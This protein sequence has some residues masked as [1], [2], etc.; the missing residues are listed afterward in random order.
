[1]KRNPAMNILIVAIIFSVIALS[2]AFAALQTSL[3][4]VGTATIPEGTKWEVKFT[5]LSNPIINGITSSDIKEAV[6]SSTM[7]KLKVELGK[8]FDSVTYTFNVENTGT[9][10]AKISSIV[11][12]NITTLKANDLSYSFTYVDESGNESDIKVGDTL[13]VGEKKKLKLSIKYDEIDSL[14]QTNPIELSFD[15]SIVYGQA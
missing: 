2:I 8:P 10:D 9:I 6:L 15:S 14:N 13:N 1:M 5:N 12:P 4:I 11:T 3:Q 7:F